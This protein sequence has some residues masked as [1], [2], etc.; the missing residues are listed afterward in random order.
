MGMGKTSA[1]LAALDALK[2]VE[3]N[4]V[5]VIAPKLVATT[6]WADDVK[7]F[8]EFRHLKV[9]S[10][11]GDV[12][13]RRQALKE[14]ADIHTINY[15]LLPWLILKE[16]K[17]GW[18]TVIADE[19][20]RLKSFRLRQG[21][22]QSQAL[23]KVAWSK[24]QRFVG[25]TGTVMPNGL[26]DLWGQYWFLDKGERLGHSFSA[27]I[28][29]WFRYP[30]PDA[31]NVVPMPGAQE[32]IQD[33]IK[34]ITLS[35]DVKDWFDIADPILTNLYVDLPPKAMEI[36]KA[37]EKELFVQIENAEIEANNMAAKSLKCL[38][39]ANGAVYNSDEERTWSQVHD[40]KLD[41]LE[42]LIEE[43]N[44]ANIIVAYHFQHDLARLKKR[45]PHAVTHDGTDKAIRRWNR[46][47]IQLLLLHP[48]SAGHGLNLQYG[49]NI[50]VFFGHNWNLEHYLQIVER[51]GPVR[52][53]QA[54]F[55]RPVFIYNIVARNTIDE[56]VIESRA[57]KK[58]AQDILLEFVKRK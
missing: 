18:E 20:T 24:V 38:Q 47:E 41:M 29:R 3:D 51:I 32:E 14:P 6:V 42:N 25:L 1:T 13:E 57:Q 50:L 48:A 39:I 4:R 53:K 35:L 2:L 40:V 44:G 54:G 16:K 52:Q 26:I 56:L 12:Y 33:K 34:D 17:W 23:S 37:M 31:Y 27:Y 11:S 19:V 55:N 9:V 45:F 30:H 46:G 22:K 43:C 5:L 28:A 8:D 36:Y 49:G 58:K 15:E 10:I 7:K 21:G